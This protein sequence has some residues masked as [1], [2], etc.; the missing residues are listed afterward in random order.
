MAALWTCHVVRLLG[1]FWFCICQLSELRGDVGSKFDLFRHVF[2]IALRFQ[3]RR[4]A[5]ELFY[6]MNGYSVQ[7]KMCQTSVSNI[8]YRPSACN[9]LAVWNAMLFRDLAEYV[10]EPVIG[11]C[12]N[13]CWST[14]LA[15]FTF[16]D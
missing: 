13:T 8:V 6:A 14:E 3:D 9:L 16:C 5:S 7:S 11:S 10:S 1:W 4:M 15:L 2:E 12:Q